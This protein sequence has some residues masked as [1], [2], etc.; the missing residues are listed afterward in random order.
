MSE[1]RNKRIN[2]YERNIR[3]NM[4]G[5]EDKKWIKVRKNE[6]EGIVFSLKGR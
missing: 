1:N 2:E 4:E 5:N 6:D 3:K